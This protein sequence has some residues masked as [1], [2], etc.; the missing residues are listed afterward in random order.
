MIVQE[1]TDTHTTHMWRLSQT[2]ATGRPST[3][4]SHTQTLTMR[5]AAIHY[6]C[7]CLCVFYSHCVESVW[8]TR[9]VRFNASAR[10]GGHNFIKVVH[11]QT[12]LMH[13]A[14]Y[15]TISNT[16]L[17]QMCAMT[18]A[19]MLWSHWTLIIRYLMRFVCW[20]WFNVP[21]HIARLRTRAC[22]IIIYRMLTGC[23]WVGT[24]TH[25]ALGQD[26]DQDCKR[27][28]N[29]PKT[30]RYVHFTCTVQASIAMRMLLYNW[31]ALQLH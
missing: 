6:I 11:T 22:N 4:S 18:I 1:H 2:V 13:V 9:I 5:I 14:S 21:A 25:M 23:T 12:H 20:W 30:V 29:E 15:V 8:W 27:F 31:K 24:R 26:Q 19:L 3:H 10:F 28:A 7:E 16:I 17:V